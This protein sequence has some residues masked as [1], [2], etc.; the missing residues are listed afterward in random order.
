[1]QTFLAFSNSIWFNLTNASLLAPNQI[2]FKKLI[3]ESESVGGDKTDTGH[4]FIM[5]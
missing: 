3:G 4:A 1:M 5:E 2:I